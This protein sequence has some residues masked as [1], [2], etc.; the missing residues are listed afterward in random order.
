MVLMEER[1][2]WVTAE[3]ELGFVGGSPGWPRA[4]SW[5]PPC[6]WMNLSGMEGTWPQEQGREGLGCSEHAALMSHV[7][8]LARKPT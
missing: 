4:S 1:R 3:G 7:G 8:E 2:G 5:S 6:P